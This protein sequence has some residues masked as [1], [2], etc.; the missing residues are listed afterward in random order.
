MKASRS[1]AALKP[2][3]EGIL[4]VL[5]EP[6]TI[7]PPSRG[8]SANCQLDDELSITETLDVALRR[9]CDQSQPDG[10]EPGRSRQRP[11]VRPERRRASG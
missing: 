9:K 2:E 1:N 7:R 8:S 5:H 4:A 6:S 10:S 3:R 11:P